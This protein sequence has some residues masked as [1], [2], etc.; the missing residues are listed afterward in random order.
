MPTGTGGRDVKKKSD[1]CK[2]NEMKLLKTETTITI[3]L[4]L[5][6]QGMGEGR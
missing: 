6:L 3:V 4:E 2:E 5:L 1:K